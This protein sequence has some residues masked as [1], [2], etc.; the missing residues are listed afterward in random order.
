MGKVQ[1]DMHF[2]NRNYHRKKWKPGF[3]SEILKG[4]GA[5]TDQNLSYKE[6]FQYGHSLLERS[7]GQKFRIFNEDFRHTIGDIMVTL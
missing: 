5:T 4:I 6:R 3:S 7:D 2:L 1:L